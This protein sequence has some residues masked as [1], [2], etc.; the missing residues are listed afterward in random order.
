MISA[1]VLMPAGKEHQH[2][3]AT[4]PLLAA[5]P[6]DDTVVIESGHEALRDLR[7]DFSRLPLLFRGFLAFAQ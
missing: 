3:A 1:T 5:G 4:A 7:D 2:G 6:L